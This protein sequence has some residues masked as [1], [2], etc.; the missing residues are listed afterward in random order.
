MRYKVLI[1]SYL[2]SL[3]KSEAKV[4]QYTLKNSQKILYETLQTVSKKTG[5]GEATVLRF[6]NKIGCEKFANLK[7]MIAQETS[8]EEAKQASNIIESIENDLTEILRNTTSILDEKAVD[9]AAN[10]IDRAEYLY[11]FGVGSSGLSA[12]EAEANFMRIGVPSNAIADPHFQA[13]VASTLSKNDVVVAFTISG[14]TRDIY[15]SCKIAKSQG[16]KLVV[17]TNYIESPT[18]KLADCILLTAANEHILRGGT[19]GG[20]ISQLFVIDCVKDKYVVKHEK[21]AKKLN[22]K[23]AQSIVNKVI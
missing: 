3:T 19:L 22:T 20:T 13:M 15:D 8:Q 9:V 14:T 18:A 1:Q 17:I 10:L 12:K 7:L 6:C 4:A 2:P 21:E 16:A 23:V 11:F 5:V